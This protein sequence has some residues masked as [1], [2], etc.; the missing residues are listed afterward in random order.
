MIQLKAKVERV[1][2]PREGQDGTWYILKTDAAVCK[3]TISWRPTVGEQIAMAGTW[4]E[5]KGEQEFQFKEIWHDLPNDSRAMLHYACELTKGIGPKTEEDIWEALG[6][7]WTQINYDQVPK[8]KG[9]LLND[10]RETIAKLEMEK[11]KTDACTWLISF[12]ATRRMAEAA[13]K[14]WDQKTIGA[15]KADCYRLAELPNYSFKDVDEKI[16]QRFGIEDADTRRVCAAINY[17]MKQL[18]DGPTAVPWW[19]LREKV[20]GAIALPPTLVNQC[21]A[22]MFRDGSL[23]PFPATQHIALRADYQNEK[24]IWDYANGE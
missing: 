23:H 5:Y 3:G 11:E 20:L 24:C 16:R 10:F 13:W 17:Y 2:F 22:E 6:E 21:V 1:L 14:E 18:A 8:M 12:G 7:N 15:V 9:A 19:A 4:K